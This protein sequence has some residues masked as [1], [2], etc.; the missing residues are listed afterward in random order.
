[1][2]VHLTH[3]EIKFL[4]EKVKEELKNIYILQHKFKNET[5]R[6]PRYLLIDADTSEDVLEK[7]TIG[8]LKCEIKYKKMVEHAKGKE[9]K[10]IH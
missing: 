4:L 9:K 5:G 3:R 2:K 7:L 1:M 10:K 6:I 8:K